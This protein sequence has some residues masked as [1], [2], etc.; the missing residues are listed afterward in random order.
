MVT[1]QFSLN[2]KFNILYYTFWFGG[3]SGIVERVSFPPSHSI[4]PP[5]S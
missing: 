1:A 3:V 2:Y 4:E 5:F